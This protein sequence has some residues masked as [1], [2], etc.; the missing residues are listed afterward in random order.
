[1]ANQKI[2]DYAAI[3]GA[4][5]DA[6]ADLIE[7]VD[8][9]ALTNKKILV[10]EL[11]KVIGTQGT[12]TATLTGCTTSPT[13]TAAFSITNNVVTLDIPPVTATSNTTAC[14]ITGLPAS[15]APTSGKFFS[16]NTI[17]NGTQTMSGCSIAAG[18]QTI[19]LT[20]GTSPSS[21]FTASGTKGLNQALSISYTLS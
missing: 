16:A 18:A 10:N 20:N 7:I 21:I 2:T 6:T 11:G 12:F 9:S 13:V 17:D 3:T 5:V 4:N 14:T 1:M 19:V 15:I 8:F